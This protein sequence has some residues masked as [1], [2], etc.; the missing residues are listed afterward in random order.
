MILPD[1]FFK[2]VHGFISLPEAE[3]LYKLASEVLPGG[4][5]VEIGSYQGRSTCALAFGAK[6]HNGI[7]WA[8]DHHPTYQIGA[9]NYSIEDLQFYYANLAH[10]QLGR[11]VR[12]INLHSDRAFITW[13]ND[14]ELLFIDGNH[15]FEQVHKDWTFWSPLSQVVALHDTAGYHASIDRL[16][17]N[18]IASGTWERS[19]MVDSLSIFRRIDHS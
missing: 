14:I 4:N 1:D 17:E 6:E 5:I 16:V 7:V 15:E 12:T 9:T 19:E 11:Y 10:Y 3:L 2:Q 18:I 8:I 13:Q